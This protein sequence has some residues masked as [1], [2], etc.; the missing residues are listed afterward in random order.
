MPTERGR[1]KTLPVGSPDG[2]G[3]KKKQSLFRRP[4]LSRK[5]TKEQREQKIRS[6]SKDRYETTNSTSNLNSEEKEE[7]KEKKAKSSSLPRDLKSPFGRPSSKNK[8][9][10]S[11]RRTLDL[12]N[13]LLPVRPLADCVRRSGCSDVEIPEIVKLLICEV[14]SRGLQT[15]DIYHIQGQKSDVREIIR[16]FDH[17]EEI[18]LDHVTIHTI[19][20]SLKDFIQ[21]LPGNI[22]DCVKDKLEES[23][24]E[25]E[26][27]ESNTR[28]LLE[29]IPN[30]NYS[31]SSWLF[32]HINNIIK[33]YD[34]NKL[35][36]DILSKTWSQVLSISPYLVMGMSRNA[37]EFFG[38]LKLEKGRQ[39]LRWKD[40][41]ADLNIPVT[42]VFAASMPASSVPLP[43]LQ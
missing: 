10:P 16:Q 23:I 35:T 9:D 34:S 8:K 28:R 43:P 29:L 14:E 13:Q 12:D 30:S 1:D 5:K 11:R 32:T 31:L 25:P 37:K 3:R 42:L 24:L 20:S 33:N 4:S 15:R 36:D 2:E 22:L 17:L 38:D 39:V 27:F 41:T 21:S 19:T 7:K 40:S 18:N 6:Q 26:T